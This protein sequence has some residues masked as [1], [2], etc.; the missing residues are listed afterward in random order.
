MFIDHRVVDYEQYYASLAA[1][2]AAS[3]QATPSGSV[4]GSSD[5]DDFGEE[6]ED[7]KPSIE[8]LNSLNDYRKRSRSQ[9]D[10]GSAGRNKIPKTES[11][12]S[13]PSV[14]SVPSVPVDINVEDEVIGG[15]SGSAPKEDPIV[16][17]NGNPIPFSEVTEEHHEMMTPEEYTA[18]FEV[19]QS[20]EV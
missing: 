9:E 4:P 8:Y 7:R 10:E 5:F 15:N 6:E 20:M 11:L 1:S 16:Y 13:L 19:M 17:V 3:A 18:Y 14:P 2:A 12:T